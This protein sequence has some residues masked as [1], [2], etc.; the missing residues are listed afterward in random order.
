MT[1][2]LPP[3]GSSVQSALVATTKLAT[4][5]L[6]RSYSQAAQVPSSN[7]IDKSSVQSGKEFQN[8]CGFRFPECIR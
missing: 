1:L 5:G 8:G 2:S 3:V 6:S 4:R 7:V